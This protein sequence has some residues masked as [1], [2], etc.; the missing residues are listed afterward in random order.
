LDRVSILFEDVLRANLQV[1]SEEVE[2]EWECAD[3]VDFDSIEVDLGDE[4]PQT[5]EVA[6]MQAAD[7]AF[8]KA[9]GEGAGDV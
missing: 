9:T 8:E 7:G 4:V 3:G 1:S 2:E 5:L 6:M